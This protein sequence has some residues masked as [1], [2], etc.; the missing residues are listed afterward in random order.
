MLFYPLP[1]AYQVG[2][3][4]PVSQLRKQKLREAEQ[5][6]EGH[7]ALPWQSW[8]PEVRFRAFTLQSASCAVATGVLG[9]DTP[10][11]WCLTGKPLGLRGGGASPSPIMKLSCFSNSGPSLVLQK[12]DTGRRPCHE[13]AQGP[14]SKPL[15]YSEP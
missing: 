4:I 9:L 8:S 10:P 2:A 5:L 13:P 3:E 7:T 6:A 11:K 14:S 15:S 1:C 12:G